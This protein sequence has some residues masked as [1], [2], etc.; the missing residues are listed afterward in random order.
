MPAQETRSLQQKH[1]STR[2]P[3]G[4]YTFRTDV[5]N[6]NSISIFIRSKLNYIFIMIALSPNK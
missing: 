3:S 6:N 2:Y 5:T 4:R 1:C